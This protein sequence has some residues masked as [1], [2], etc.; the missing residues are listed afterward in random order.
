MKKHPDDFDKYFNDLIPPSGASE[1]EEGEMLRAI[2]KIIYRHW[3]DGDYFYYDYGI[4][5]AG[6]P[7]IYL[8]GYS[9]LRDKLNPIL[10]SAIG[11]KRSE[12]SDKL[13][14]V[15]DIILEDIRSK[16]GKY[17]KNDKDMLD[18]Y[19]E[20]AEEF[21]YEDNHRKYSSG[22]LIGNLNKTYS[23]KQLFE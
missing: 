15:L 19:E 2:N 6:S 4:E 1:Y 18:Y 3:N 9:P 20:A 10:T 8:T 17:T 12:Y 7:Y 16:Q 11:K 13:Y 22:G 23:L 14:E 5:T 21:G